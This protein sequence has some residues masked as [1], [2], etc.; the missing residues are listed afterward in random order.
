MT[1]IVDIKPK[2]VF[3]RL[4]ALYNWLKEHSHTKTNIKY[5]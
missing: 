3:E 1:L 5:D 2:M 4:S